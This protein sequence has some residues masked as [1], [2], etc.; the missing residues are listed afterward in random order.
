[1][2]DLRG[3][4]LL[5][6]GGTAFSC[7]IVRAAHLMG[8]HVMVTDY[9]ADSPAK[10]M[11]DESFMVNAADVDALEE[12]CRKQRIDGVLTGFADSLLLSAAELC[13]RLGL[14]FY[15][16]REQLKITLDKTAFKRECR[17]YGV[18]VARQY[19]YFGGAVG[20]ELA[21]AFPVIVKPVDG[22]GGRGITICEFPEELKQAY[23]H[24]LG[25]S[26]KGEVLVEHYVKGT[27]ATAFYAFEDGEVTLLGVADR[28]VSKLASSGII[29]LPVAYGFPSVETAR[30][31]AS[32]HPKL[33]EMFRGLG[34]RNGMVFLQMMIEDGDIV[35]LEPGY[36]L[37]GSL[38]YH[39]TKRDYG[40][41]ALERMIRF[42]LTG[43]MGEPRASE[44][45]HGAFTRYYANLTY[46]ARPGTIG[47]MCTAQELS[48]LPGVITAVPAYWEGDIIPQAAEG[49]LMQVFMRA[50][51]QADTVADLRAVARLV[52]RAVHIEDAS[53]ES[54]LLPAFDPERFMFPTFRR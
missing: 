30:F 25:F 50:F 42:A 29:P 45:A 36:R 53:G 14:P 1:M 6:L 11:A 2:I 13:E 12:L 4:R 27:E 47:G 5:V 39:I 19:E 10:R 40:Y 20:G 8:V 7:E 33:T 24:A 52:T 54:M 38:E 23:E 34:M 3:K 15:A 44:C 18:P 16:T 9:N 35:V 43:T 17:R 41:S 49:T 21:D 37:T 31:I 32:V 48:A 28:Y 22:S 51:I 46:L 26:K